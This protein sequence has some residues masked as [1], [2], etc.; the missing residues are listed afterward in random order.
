MN[1]MNTHIQDHKE[2]PVHMRVLWTIAVLCMLQPLCANVSFAQVKYSTFSR[3]DVTGT[4]GISGIRGAGGQNV[5]ITAGFHPN[6]TPTPTCSPGASPSSSGLLYV[7][8]L[9]GGGN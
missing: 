6:P 2:R 3:P 7:G 4:T 8:P 1:P 9:T 5:L